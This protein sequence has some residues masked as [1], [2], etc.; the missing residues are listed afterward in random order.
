MASYRPDVYQIE[1]NFNNYTTQTCK[2][3]N[4]FGLF[5]NFTFRKVYFV[6]FFTPAK[7]FLSLIK[8]FKVAFSS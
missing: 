6:D 3:S 1:F 4:K 5:F 8:T 7:V 2:I